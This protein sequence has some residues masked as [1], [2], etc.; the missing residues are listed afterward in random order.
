MHGL[1]CR[2]QFSISMFLRAVLWKE[3]ALE[4]VPATAA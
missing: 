1:N 3:A 2:E 4:P